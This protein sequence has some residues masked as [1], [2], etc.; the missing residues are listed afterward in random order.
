MKGGALSLRRWLRGRSLYCSKLLTA[1]A[2]SRYLFLTYLVTLHLLVLLC[3]TGVLWIHC[4]PW[5]AP[6]PVGS[7][8][9]SPET[10]HVLLLRHALDFCTNPWLTTRNPELL[11]WNLCISHLLQS[12]LELPF[13]SGILYLLRRKYSPLPSKETAAYKLFKYCLWVHNGWLLLN[14]L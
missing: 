4:I 7:A 8:N 13:N 5:G 10:P 2:K 9:P 1:R 12:G 11:Q 14:G 6:F 3:L